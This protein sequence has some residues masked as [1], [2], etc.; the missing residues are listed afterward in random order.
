LYRLAHPTCHQQ[1]SAFVISAQDLLQ[2]DRLMPK[3]GSDKVDL[4][5]WVCGDVLE[6]AD[7]DPYI[8]FD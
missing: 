5:L 4:A 3:F 1:R 8:D 6:L 7:V 2:A